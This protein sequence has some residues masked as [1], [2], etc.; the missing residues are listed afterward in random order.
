LVAKIRNLL[1]KESLVGVQLDGSDIAN[2]IGEQAH[3]D[4]DDF[5]LVLAIEKQFAEHPALERSE[6]EEYR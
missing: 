2:N 6:D 4:V 1:P 3:T 5:F